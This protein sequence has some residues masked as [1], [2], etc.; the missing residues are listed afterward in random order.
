MNNCIFYETRIKHTL[1]FAGHECGK[2]VYFC[3]CRENT[4][5]Q[6]ASLSE[7]QI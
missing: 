6:S 4:R 7:I 3:L 5:G 1:E 2:A